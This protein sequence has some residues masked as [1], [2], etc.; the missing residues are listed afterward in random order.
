M[1]T[2][3]HEAI[4]KYNEGLWILLPVLCLL[5]ISGLM[6]YSCSAPNID[7]VMR[8]PYHY[9]FRQS[10][11]ALLGMSALIICWFVPYR[12]W[13]KLAYPILF[14]SFFLLAMVFSPMGI[15]TKAGVARWIKI[16]SFTFQPVEFAKFALV[17]YLA[18]SLAKKREQVLEFGIGVV[19][20]I[21]VLI[22]FA[23]F[24]MAQPDF[25][26]VVIFTLIVWILMFF[27]EVPMRSL[28]LPVPI[29]AGIM[30]WFVYSMPYRMNR[31]IGFLHPI[32]TASNEGFQLTRSLIAMGTG[33][34]FGLG[35]GNGHM[36]MSYLPEAHTDFIFSII[37]EEL[38]LCGVYLVLI[39]FIILFF[40]G[41]K[42][43]MTAPDRFGTYLAAG[44]TIS[45]GIQVIINT[46]VS[47]G[48]MPT[49]G[50]ALPFLSYGGS[51]LVMNLA[52]MGILMNIESSRSKKR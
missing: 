27:A 37:G 48:L 51:A 20:H 11:Y 23:G 6:V 38:G 7:T 35:P 24:L 9:F 25:G 30:A 21:L 45:L 32:D 36:K 44:I 33:G 40:M 49:K 12:I 34:V 29:I 50:L 47:L 13:G 10:L 46:G 18:Y 31:I 3:E 43:A 1:K 15:A 4:K 52:L 14:F 39:L 22:I 5:F 42:I 26:S 28:L 8:S 19:P 16:G 17:L 41:M 2:S